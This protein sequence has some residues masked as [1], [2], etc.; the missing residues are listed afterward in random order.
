V[1]LYTN[2]RFYA[3]NHLSFPYKKNLQ[4][5]PA[6]TELVKGLAI[7]SEYK[8]RHAPVPIVGLITLSYSPLITF[9]V[10]L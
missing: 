7:T 4:P 1:K 6:F 8:A 9:S 3:T 2:F 10:T 5:Y